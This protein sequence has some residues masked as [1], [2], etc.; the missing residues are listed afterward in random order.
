MYFKVPYF[1]V[2]VSDTKI[3]CFFFRDIFFV[4][5]TFIAV[6]QEK[7]KQNNTIKKERM[8]QQFITSKF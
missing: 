3:Y 5:N 6:K 7:T 8:E 2:I 4:F 1:V